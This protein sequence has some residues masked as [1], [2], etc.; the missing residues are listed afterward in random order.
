MTKRKQKI[1]IGI[2]LAVLGLG[3]TLAFIIPARY[4]VVVLSF[5]LIVSGI[6]LCKSC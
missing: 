6:V 1:N 2:I 5:A 4:L 3:L